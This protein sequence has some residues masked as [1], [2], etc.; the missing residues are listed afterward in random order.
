[1]PVA[2]P[3]V[4]PMGW[5][6]WDA[7][8]ASVTEDETLQNAEY[9]ARH[10]SGFGWEYVVVDIQWYEPGADGSEYHPWADLA[11]DEWGRLQP[12]VSRF[13]SA[14]GNGF[15]ILAEKIHALGLKF[16]IHIMRGIPR[17]A[18][19]ANTPVKGMPGVTA[20]DIAH[21]NSIC[22]W[23]TDMY[24]VNP[25]HPGAQA[26]YDGLFKMYADWG[27]D[28]VKVDD[29][30]WSRL[31]GYH[32]REVELIH[33]SIERCGRDMVLSLSPGPAPLSEAHHLKKHA[34]MWRLTDDLWDRWD[35]VLLAFE[36][37]AAWSGVKTPGA[38]PDPDML[39]L[40]HI[41]IRSS[42][43]GGGDRWTRLTRAEQRALM[44]LWAIAGAPLIMGG[45]LR[46][47][48]GWTSGL[49]T[50]RSV[51]HVAMHAYGSHEAHCGNDMRIWVARDTREPATYLAVFNLAG[52]ARKVTIPEDLVEGTQLVRDLWQDE[53]IGQV[54]TSFEVSLDSHDGTLLKLTAV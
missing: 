6:S 41:G 13:P 35:D 22:P 7:F 5:N 39:P 33:R 26:Y 30:A 11:M 9:M 38:Y 49:M 28:F 32:M 40:G 19:H 15:R 17:Q 20:R 29:I 50:N 34:T 2:R 3:L 48:D 47:L 24:G 8:G 23:N 43:A 44:T 42:A 16:G 1:V 36:K 52:N 25:D 21:P 53:E 12:A 14:D 46:D 54:Q 18:V 45:D 27:V 51:L 31:Y 37:L 4:P 10:L